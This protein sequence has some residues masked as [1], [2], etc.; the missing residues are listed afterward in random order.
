MAVIHPFFCHRVIVYCCT[1][2]ALEDFAIVK[3]GSYLTCIVD[4]A[5][6]QLH[7]PPLFATI[8]SPTQLAC[9][10]CN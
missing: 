3:L 6:V 8:D 5:S 10:L 1:L 2:T 7:F 9:A 4:G